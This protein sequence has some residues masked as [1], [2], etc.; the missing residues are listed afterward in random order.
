MNRTTNLFTTIVDPKRDIYLALDIVDPGKENMLL[1]CLCLYMGTETTGSTIL[2]A[3]TVP[4]IK[5]GE[6]YKIKDVPK[7]HQIIF[8]NMMADLP[9]EEGTAQI[10][11]NAGILEGII[12]IRGLKA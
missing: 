1:A 6:I 4:V 8:E 5:Q 2:A 10:S 3:T 12:S 11:A 7:K 9:F